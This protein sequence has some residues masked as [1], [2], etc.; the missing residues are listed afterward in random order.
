MCNRKYSIVM[1]VFRVEKY[2][3]RMISCVKNQTYQNWELILVDDCSDDN[4]GKLCDQFCQEDERIQ[5]IHLTCNQ[6]LSNARNKGMEQATGE[7]ILFLDSDDWVECTLLQSVEQSLQKN[8]AQMVIYG[9]VEEYENKAGVF[10][11]KKEINCETKFLT[12]QKQI[13]REV[14]QLEKKTLFGY[15]WNKAYELAWLRKYHLQFEKITMIEDVLFNTQAIQSMTSVNLLC[16]MLYH[17]AIRDNGNLTSKYLEDYFE[18]HVK[19][20]SLFLDLYKQWGCLNRTVK[21]ILA[22]IYCRYFLSALQRNCDSR[23]HMSQKQ[24]RDWIRQCFQ[25]EVFQQLVPY[26][27]PDN[28]ILQLLAICIRKK[29]VGGCWLMGEVIYVVK[30]KCPAIFARLKQ[31]R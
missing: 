14:I 25:S 20:I 30:N 27:A 12:S 7:Y 13:Y 5:V 21:T 8:Q 26:L 18:L 11:Y 17:Y 2:L 28:R 6:G 31:N 4:S 16:D 19:R 15:A 23:S 3:E 9:L 10:D 24:K 29:N 22:G 1:P